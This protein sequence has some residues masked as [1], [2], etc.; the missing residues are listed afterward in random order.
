MDVARAYALAWKYA[1]RVPEPV[2]R[3]VTNLAA[4]VTW[5][6]RT[7]GVRRLEANLARVCPE[8][9][10]R[11][12]RRTS[13]AGM[14]SYLR[15]FGETFA[16][17]CWGPE[18]IA[19][20][21]R[22]TGVENL[23]P[24]LDAGR[25]VLLALGHT[26]N[27]DLAGAWATVHLAPV[28]TV[29]ERLEP[30]E[31]FQ[32]FLAFRE[33][34]GVRILPL[35]GGGDVFRTLVRTA[36]GGPGLLPLLADRDLTARGVEVDIA[37]RRARVAAGPASL[38]V[39]TG[40]RLVPTFVHYERL[41]GARRRAARSPWGLVIAFAPPVPVPADLPRPEQVAAVTQAWVDEL[42]DGI[43]RHPQDWH[44][45]Q[46]VFVEDLDPQRYAA[47]LAAQDPATE[48]AG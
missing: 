10:G 7:A 32:E 36:R 8:L 6:R 46:R 1:G 9:T 4:D 45:L 20:R 5:A 41:H 26:G 21:V 43:R 13:R 11:A 22:A 3:G 39:T 48:G 25:T 35:T 12:L 29:A 24:E 16:M 19:A 18:Q 30:E 31:L 2:L 33:S 28:T 47:T 38:A 14:R 17:S 37:G 40:A 44:M 23:R 42:V 27:W 34:L 15:Y